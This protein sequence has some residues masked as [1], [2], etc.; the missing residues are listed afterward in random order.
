MLSIINVGRNFN[1]WDIGL[2]IYVLLWNREKQNSHMTFLKTKYADGSLS[3][4]GISITLQFISL[5]D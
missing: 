4:S 5:G 2:L 1:L 3:I